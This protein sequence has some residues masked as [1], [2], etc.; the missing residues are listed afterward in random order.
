MNPFYK[1][2]VCDG[3]GYRERKNKH[4]HCYSAC[5]CWSILRTV[6]EIEVWSRCWAV[7]IRCVERFNEIVLSEANITSSFYE[8]SAS[9]VIFTAMN[10]NSAN[11][12]KHI[13][14][15]TMT[16]PHKVQY[17]AITKTTCPFI[18]SIAIVCLFV[19]FHPFDSYTLHHRCARMKKPLWSLLFL[20][21]NWSAIMNKQWQKKLWTK[22]KKRKRYHSYNSR[23]TKKIYKQPNAE[24]RRV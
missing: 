6:P 9:H 1:N 5:V 2:K 12:I 23:G 7:F 24:V 14:I 17:I 10:Y 3:R 15:K 11:N 16:T 22:H 20:L 4:I 19:I 21:F 13:E 8:V 18:S